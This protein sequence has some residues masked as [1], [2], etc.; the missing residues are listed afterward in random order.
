MSEQDDEDSGHLRVV[1]EPSTE[2][3][4]PLVEYVLLR[5]VDTY[6]NPD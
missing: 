2:T 4:R 3:D 6:W 5:C 1:H